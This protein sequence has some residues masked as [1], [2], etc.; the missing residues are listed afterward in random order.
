[1]L[2]FVL[3]LLTAS[4]FCVTMMGGGILAVLINWAVIAVI[5]VLADMIDGAKNTLWDIAGI[6]IF[7]PVVSSLYC[8]SSFGIHVLGYDVTN[9]E[10]D[11]GKVSDVD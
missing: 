7:A 5:L 8:L 3:C 10:K 2:R 1:M 4:F 6:V 9:P 11:V